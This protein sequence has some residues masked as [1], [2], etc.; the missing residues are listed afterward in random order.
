MSCKYLFLSVLFILEI[1]GFL[2]YTEVLKCLLYS[3]DLCYFL[4]YG[5]WILI[6]LGQLSLVCT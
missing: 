1:C 6:Q 5:F 2:N 3:D 4:I